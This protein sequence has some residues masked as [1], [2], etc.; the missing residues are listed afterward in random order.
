MRL[1]EIR[2]RYLIA[3][4]S[5]LLS[6]Q[7]ISANMVTGMGGRS[8]VRHPAEVHRRE[9][10]PTSS[11][12]WRWWRG[13]RPRP[14]L[15]LRAAAP[16]E[17]LSAGSTVGHGEIRGLTTLSP[18]GFGQFPITPFSNLNGQCADTLTT[19]D[20]LSTMFP[21]R[22]PRNNLT[23]SEFVLSLAGCSLIAFLGAV[24]ILY[25]QTTYEWFVFHLGNDEMRRTSP[26]RGRFQ[27]WAHRLCGAAML[28][29]GLFFIV[30]LVPERIAP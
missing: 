1:S 14:V 28:L 8:Q 10:G 5:R 27:L 23:S 12:M 26:E 11:E 20:V 21:V 24:V 4:D 7:T 17:R 3:I 15:Q 19:G 9:A 6:C 22:I 16:D 25:P 30:V 13:C 18:Q 2:A 29:G